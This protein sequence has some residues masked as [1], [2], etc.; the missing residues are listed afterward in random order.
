M[1]MPRPQFT[2]RALLVL[3]LAV[4]CFFGGIRFERERHWREYA[5]DLM[6]RHAAFEEALKVYVP[7][8]ADVEEWEAN[9]L[10][11]THGLSA[12]TPKSSPH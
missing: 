10:S 9:R 5:Q 3:L 12:T 2:L 8:K 1:T 7:S 4:A 11:R 6:N